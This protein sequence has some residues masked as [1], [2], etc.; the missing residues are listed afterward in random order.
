MHE[1]LT[2]RNFSAPQAGEISEVL[3]FAEK[4]GKRTQGVVKLLGADPIQN[5]EPQY[6]P[7]V[8]KETKLSAFID[9]GRN[10][11]I[12]V[13]RMAARMAIE[14]CSDTG[15]GIIGTTN[16]YASTGAL[17]FYADEIASKDFVGIIMSGSPKG[18]AP[19]GSIDPIFGTN[20]VAFG[21]PTEGDPII[22][23][24][25]TSAIS[26][27]E[28]V[29]T[30]VLGGELPDGV[31][32]D[33]HGG[34][35]QDPEKAMAGAIHPFDR[36]H[37][38]SGLSMMIEL[39]TGPMMGETSFDEET[40]KWYCGNLFMAIDPDLFVGRDEFKKNS[41]FLL[42]KMKN[43][44]VNDEFSEVPVPGERSMLS[45]RVTDLSGEIEIEDELIEGLSRI[46]NSNE[47]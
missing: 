8:N 44:R 29:R 2:S 34:P 43:S 12:L 17:G 13:G 27:Y 6:T 5:V 26:W 32:I 18:V 15:L 35:T 20:P 19:H 14:K 47:Y 22:F 25:A 23:D 7:T 24:M 40:G 33:A 37:K 11:G 45:K 10:P 38:G 4:T 21:F 3:L 42:E 41:S 28:L 46:S 9:G 16:T 39:L 31:A 1:V 36:G 30:K